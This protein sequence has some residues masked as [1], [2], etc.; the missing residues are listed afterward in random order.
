MIWIIIY[1]IVGLIWS[2]VTDHFNEG[3]IDNSKD[4]WLFR[5]LSTVFWP[6]ELIALIIILARKT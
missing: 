5:T 4:L 3:L 1:L 2:V 6:I